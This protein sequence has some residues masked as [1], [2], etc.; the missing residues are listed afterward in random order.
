MKTH[1]QVKEMVELLENINCEFNS[2]LQTD[3]TKGI[4]IGLKWVLN[5]ETGDVQINKGTI[6]R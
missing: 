3:L 1:R 2:E 5:G 6:T 4:I